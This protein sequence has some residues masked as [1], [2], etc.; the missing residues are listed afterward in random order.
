MKTVPSGATHRHDPCKYAIGSF[1][2]FENDQ[3]FAWYDV[4][5][6][7]WLPVTYPDWLNDIE[8]LPVTESKK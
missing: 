5:D 6:G 1:L 3:W 2:K 4:G 8:A 7:E